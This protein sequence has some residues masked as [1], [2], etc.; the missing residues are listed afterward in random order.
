M[1]IKDRR[2][3]DSNSYFHVVSEALMQINIK[4]YL[5]ILNVTWQRKIF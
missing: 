2:N 5:E 4:T 1:Y 3:K